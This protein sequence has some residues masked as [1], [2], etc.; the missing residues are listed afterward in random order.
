MSTSTIQAGARIWQR[1]PGATSR[2]P[3]GKLPE[4]SATEPTCRGEGGV[5]L[6]GGEWQKVG[7]SRS[8]RRDAALVILYA[9]ASAL[10]AE[11][12]HLLFQHSR[13]LIAGKTALL[14]TNRLSTVRM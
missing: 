2:A 12:E 7:L 9:P 5:Q 10:D 4:G 8:F 13:G 1:S 6:S 3:A 14:I 11:A